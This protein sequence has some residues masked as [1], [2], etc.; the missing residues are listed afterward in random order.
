M[1]HATFIS[2]CL[3]RLRSKRSSRKVALLDVEAEELPRAPESA[4]C[5]AKD[6][7]VVDL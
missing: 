7:N 3:L 5:A 2:Q 6:T 1:Q 4:A